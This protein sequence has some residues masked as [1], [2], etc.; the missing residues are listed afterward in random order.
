MGTEMTSNLAAL[1]ASAKSA[2]ATGASTTELEPSFARLLDQIQAAPGCRDEVAAL[3]IDDI[4]TGP[5]PWELIAYLMFELRWPEVNRC[6]DERL[7][8]ERDPRTKAVMAHIL[9]AFDDRWED[10]DMYRRWSR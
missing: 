9:D 4:R 3:M 10:A 7:H 5:V 2:C 8:S 6:A 1:F